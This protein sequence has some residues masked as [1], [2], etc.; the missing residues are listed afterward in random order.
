MLAGYSTTHA[1][2][3]RRFSPGAL[4]APGPGPGTPGRT[5]HQRARRRSRARRGRRAG[6]RRPGGYRAVDGGGR[7]RRRRRRRLRFRRRAARRRSGRRKRR[8]ARGGRRHRRRARRAHRDRLEATPPRWWRW[9]RPTSSAPAAR[10]A[11]RRRVDARAAGGLGPQV[12][13]AVVGLVLFAA[14]FLVGFGLDVVTDAIWYQSVGYDP[15]F[16][17]WCRHPGR[18]LPRHPRRGARLPSRQPLARGAPGPAARRRGTRAHARL[19]R[20]PRRCRALLDRGPLLHADAFGGARRGPQGGPDAGSPARPPISFEA[21][22]IPDLSPLAIV[23]L[24]VVAVLAA[25]GTA[26]AIAGSWET[27]LLW[28]NRV[29]FDATA[30]SAVVDPVFGA[31]TSPITCSSCR[32]CG[33]SR[34][35]W[36]GSSSPGSSSPAGAT[37]SPRRAAAASPPPSGFTWGSSVACTS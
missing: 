17:T 11:E 36:A 26:G 30:A 10:R 5:P 27:I 25:L 24:A 13:L 14:V 22:E 29:P 37:S 21:E 20:P 19:R 18:A 4:R 35:S 31:A 8:R 6:R 3:F 34:G 1:R 9:W 33:S 12:L 16:G 15:V 7:A 28:Q 2:P 32:S 23:G